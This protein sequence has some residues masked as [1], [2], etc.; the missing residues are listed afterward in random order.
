MIDQPGML[1]DRRA[2]ERGYQFPPSNGDWHVTL[3]CEGCLA[4]ISRWEHLVLTGRITL[5]RSI[6]SNALNWPRLPVSVY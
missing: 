4:S 3:P 6:F 2:A 5:A 1:G